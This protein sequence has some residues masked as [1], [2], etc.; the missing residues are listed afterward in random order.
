MAFRVVLIGDSAMWGQ[1]L[2]T[3]HTFAQ[4]AAA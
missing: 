1:E 3:P 4:L 2:R